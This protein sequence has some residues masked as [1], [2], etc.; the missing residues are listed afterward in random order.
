[1]EKASEV[2]RYFLELFVSQPDSIEIQEII[3]E[4]GTLLMMK[5]ANEDIGKVIG[6]QG[7][8]LFSLRQIMRMWS[9]KYNQKVF[10]KLL[11]QDESFPE[12]NKEAE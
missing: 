10:L 5:V 6:K 9:S 8:L 12:N 2:L 7:R 11:D 4:R 3:D 1:M